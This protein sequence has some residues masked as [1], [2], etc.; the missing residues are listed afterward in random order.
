MYSKSQTGGGIRSIDQSSIITNEEERP[1]RIL[2][3]SDFHLSGNYIEEAKTLLDNLL[4]AIMQSGQQ[5]DLVIFSGDM[6]DKGGKD[7]VGGIDEAF[8]TFR[9]LVIDVICD[10]LKISADRFIFT[11]GNHDVNTAKANDLEDETIERRYMNG[12]EQVSQFIKVPNLFRERSQRIEA[13]KAFEKRYYTDIMDEKYHYDLLASNFLYTIHGKSVGITSL[14]TVWRYNDESKCTNKIVLGTDQIIDSR[15]IIKDCQIKI[16]VTH[17]D[18]LELPEFE[19]E[20][21]KEMIA[22]NYDVFFAGHTHCSTVDFINI[23]SG[24]SFLH[25]K[26]AGSLIANKHVSSES[27]Q[28]AFHIISYFPSHVEVTL[29][30]QENGQFFKQDKSFGNTGDGAGIYWEQIPT[31]TKS[32]ELAMIKEEQEKKQLKEIFLEKIQP[33]T[34]IEKYVSEVTD[35]FF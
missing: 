5:I 4:D 1:I 26:T 16:A 13:V 35:E 28:N 8:N 10:K 22:H 23:S 15:P 14:N 33:F 9:S 7:F 31:K 18:Y 12:E 32:I 11:P 27:Y 2:H 21:T 20:K 17:Y 29:Y 3:I 19:Q 6:I 34:T 25:V 30:K 24:Y